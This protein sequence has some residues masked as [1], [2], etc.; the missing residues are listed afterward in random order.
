MMVGS[1]PVTVH[2]VTYITQ[3]G[4]RGMFPVAGKVSFI[5]LAAKVM[6]MFEELLDMAHCKLC[7]E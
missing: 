2:T 5:T 7:T 3:G 1:Y 4:G 6:C